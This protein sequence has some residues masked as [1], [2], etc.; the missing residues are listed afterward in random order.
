MSRMVR[1]TEQLGCHNSLPDATAKKHH[2]FE[3]EKKIH[4]KEDSSSSPA[5]RVVLAL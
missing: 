5:P 1:L 4:M 3:P 2:K